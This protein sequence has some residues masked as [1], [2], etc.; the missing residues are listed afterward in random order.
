MQVCAVSALY[1]IWTNILHTHTN[2]VIQFGWD[3]DSNVSGVSPLRGLY[4]D[5]WEVRARRYG[6]KVRKKVLSGMSEQIRGQMKEIKKTERKRR[7]GEDGQKERKKAKQRAKGIAEFCKTS[8]NQW[9][10]PVLS[11]YTCLR[12]PPEKQNSWGE[13][14]EKLCFHPTVK[15]I[16][17]KLSKRPKKPKMLQCLIPNSWAW[18][19]K[20]ASWMLKKETSTR[21]MERDNLL[22]SFTVSKCCSYF[23]ISS[24]KDKK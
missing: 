8:E 2:P 4:L 23:I 17:S 21:K 22:L 18:A 7:R 3:S 14:R 24:K 16:L 1:C 10:L 12:L 20:Q 15:G 19:N 11:P 9:N 13:G 5:R 6:G